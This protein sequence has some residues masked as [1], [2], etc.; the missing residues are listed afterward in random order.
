MPQ[1]K[2]LAILGSTGSI[3]TQALEVVD[4]MP[5]KFG[6]TV[7]TANN[8]A[9]QLIAQAKKYRPKVVVIGNPQYFPD[10]QGALSGLGIEVKSGTQALEEVMEIKEIDL[11]LTALV[12]FAGLRPTLAAIHAG[13]DIALA[14]KETLVVAGELVMNLAQRKGVSILPVDSEHSA[15]FQCMMGNLHNL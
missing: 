11:V 6:V 5:D 12:G 8:R 9:E 14:N 15:L 3:G 1:K 13:K 10:V 2:Q 7:L 4:Q